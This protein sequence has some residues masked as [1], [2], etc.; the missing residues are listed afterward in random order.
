MYVEESEAAPRQPRP[1]LRRHVTEPFPNRLDERLD[2]LDS[3]FQHIANDGGIHSE[4]SVDQDVAETGHLAKLRR[5]PGRHPSGTLEQLEE[6]LVGARFTESITRHHVRSNVE[7][8]LYR[9]LKGVLDKP[10]L[11]NVVLD[12]IGVGEFGEFAQTRLDERETFA[13]EIGV[14][15]REAPG[16]RRYS[17]R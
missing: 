11:A 12:S 3:A 2:V 14:G 17:S 9:D 1:S 6:L 13:Y 16:V 5:E 15:Q 7:G 10:A 8:S 4:V